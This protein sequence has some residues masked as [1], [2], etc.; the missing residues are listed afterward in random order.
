MTGKVDKD[1]IRE[2]LRP[3][4]PMNIISDMLENRVVNDLW[5]ILYAAV[6]WQTGGSP[7][8]LAAIHEVEVDSIDGLVEKMRQWGTAREEEIDRERVREML[9]E[10]LPDDIVADA[11]EGGNLGDLWDI[12]HI[13][14]DYFTDG[15]NRAFDAIKGIKIETVDELMDHV[16]WWYNM[17]SAPN[18]W[19]D[20]EQGEEMSAGA[21]TEEMPLDEREE[22]EGEE[23]QDEERG[24]QKD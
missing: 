23:E 13:A 17:T 12:L 14:V 4:I 19:Y 5:D 20:P 22:L 11:L 2:R 1:E 3:F 9:E 6:D 7:E 21:Q 24:E 16:R 18:I 15:D 10:Y 8:A